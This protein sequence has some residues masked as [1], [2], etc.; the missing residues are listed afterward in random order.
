V[1]HVL[2]LARDPEQV[3]LGVVEQDQLAR[4]DARDLPAQLGAD[5]TAR[6]GDHHDVAFEVLAHALELDPDGLAAQH[7][8]HAQLADLTH[9]VPD[10]GQQLEH[11]RQRADGD[12]SRAAG[13][14]DAGAHRSG[15]RGDRDD[16]L[17]WLDL[18]EDAIQLVGAAEHP[19]S[20]VEAQAALAWVVVG[21]PDG[22]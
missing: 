7:V 12:P 11:R 17:V 14:D 1:A 15:R 10:A 18:V 8:L 22:S 20:V 19:Q 4:G 5:G 9:D 3:V 2:Q 16:D 21:E 6:P 13:R